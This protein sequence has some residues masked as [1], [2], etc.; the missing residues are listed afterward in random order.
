MDTCHKHEGVC[1]D[2][3]IHTKSQA[4]QWNSDPIVGSSQLSKLQ[5]PPQKIRWPH[6]LRE[7]Q[8]METSVWSVHAC[9]GTQAHEHSYTYKRLD[10]LL[11]K[12]GKV[13]QKR[14]KLHTHTQVGI[15]YFC[16]LIPLF[17]LDSCTVLFKLT[18]PFHILSNFFHQHLRNSVMVWIFNV[19]QRVMYQ[20]LGPQLT[21]LW[22]YGRNQ[23][24]GP[25]GGKVIGILERGGALA[26]L[27]CIHLIFPVNNSAVT[28]STFCLAIS[29]QGQR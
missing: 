4:W 13:T 27:P 9:M 6:V 24:V 21:V 29:L 18:F 26:P 15:K 19:P 11:G 2:P 28:Y 1:V 20:R 10:G 17:N 12:V 16:E 23:E 22:G 25:S 5:V 3:S 7:M 8:P 14:L